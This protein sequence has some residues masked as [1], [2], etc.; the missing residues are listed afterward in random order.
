MTDYTSLNAVPRSWLTQASHDLHAAR[1]N[2]D[3]G[4]HSLACFL[5]Q[6]AAEKAVVGYLYN[7]GAEHV[8]GHALA[9]LCEDA[10]AFD[11][12][13]EFIKSIAVILDRHYLGALYPQTLPGG[14][15]CDAYEAIDSERSLEIAQDVLNGVHER[16]GL[17]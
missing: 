6:Q 4:R 1:A 16:L 5:C 2:R 3:V 9:D 8:W 15:P 12:S 10:K 14:A 11:Q 7:Q 17:T 13:F